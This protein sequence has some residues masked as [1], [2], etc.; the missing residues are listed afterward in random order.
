MHENLDARFA[1]A[2]S[3]EKKGDLTSA[4]SEYRSILEIESGHREACINL[5]TIYFRLNNYKE[6]EKYYLK[7][8]ALGEDYLTYFNLGSLYYKTGEYK[9]SVLYLE[10]SR[11]LNSVFYLS[12]LVKGLSFSRMNN[13]KAAETN[14]IKVLNEN[15]Q[16]KIA[17]TALII[18]YYNANRLDDSLELLD[19]LDLNDSSN[20]KLNE[21]KI[22]IL[23]KLGKTDEIATEIKTISKISKGY[24]DYN[25]FI[26]SV[27]VDVYSD[28]YGH[29]DK[30]IE[31][32]QHKAKK[33]TGSLI[34]LSLC[35]LLKG[36]TETAI[37]YLFEA[38]KR[39]LN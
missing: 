9:K 16:N 8:L 11:N 24:I 38:K 26:K 20:V 32:L 15:P 2:L 13:I 34:S 27:P 28:K 39:S 21:L 19:R 36:E 1:A 35:H 5:G 18:I 22:N 33:E 25:N 23:N 3:F 17:L 14:F 37:D 30:K 31:L 7:A 6:S 29:I 10:K 12:S 4:V